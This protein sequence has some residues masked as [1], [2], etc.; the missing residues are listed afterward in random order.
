M[1]CAYIAWPH[2]ASV[3]HSLPCCPLPRTRLQLVLIRAPG[4]SR[5]QVCLVQPHHKDSLN[6]NTVVFRLLS[7]RL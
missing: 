1:L 3:K 4:T 5:L 2:S 7:K 6:F